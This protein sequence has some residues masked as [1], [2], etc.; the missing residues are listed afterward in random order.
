M[1]IEPYC[2]ICGGHSIGG[3]ESI[4]EALDTLWNYF[5]Q[6]ADRELNAVGFG[7]NEEMRLKILVEEIQESL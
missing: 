6:R 5:D 7:P 2:S 3:L 1:K 4:K